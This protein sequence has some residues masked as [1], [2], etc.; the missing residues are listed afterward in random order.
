VLLIDMKNIFISSYKKEKFHIKKFS[1][2]YWIAV[3]TESTAILL[4]SI[5]LFEI[6]CCGKLNPAGF[7]IH[8][9]GILFT[10]GSFIYAKCVSH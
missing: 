6:Y 3:L 1:L 4:W 8:L 7:L 9:G 10:C 2:G 5:G